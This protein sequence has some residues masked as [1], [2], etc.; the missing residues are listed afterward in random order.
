M[1]DWSSPH[2]H[3]ET[4]ASSGKLGPAARLGAA[5]AVARRA[6]DGRQ[7]RGGGSEAARRLPEIV[8]EDAVSLTDV[9]LHEQRIRGVAQAKKR[10]RP[11]A[12]PVASAHRCPHTHTRPGAP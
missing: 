1:S 3:K 7:R 12:G 11:R 4:N 6:N 8:M 2:I 5:A 10:Y 9:Q